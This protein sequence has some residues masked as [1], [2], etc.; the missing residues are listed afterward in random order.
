MSSTLTAL[1]LSGWNLDD[2]E[3]FAVSLPGSPL[4]DDNYFSEEKNCGHNIMQRALKAFGVVTHDGL[5]IAG[6]R[7]PTKKDYFDLFNLNID[8]FSKSDDHLALLFRTDSEKENKTPFLQGAYD[9][10]KPE[11]AFACFRQLAIDL[12]CTEPEGLELWA[13]ENHNL[14]NA[15]GAAIMVLG[16][17][18][19]TVTKD[20]ATAV[21][22]AAKSSTAATPAVAKRKGVTA[23]AAAKPAMTEAMIDQ[24]VEKGKPEMSEWVDAL[25][26]IGKDKM[27]GV[28]KK[29]GKTTVFT[30]I[31]KLTVKIATTWKAEGA[32][33]VGKNVFR[34]AAN[35]LTG[36]ILRRRTLFR[37]SEVNHDITK[38]LPPDLKRHEIFIIENEI[39]S[40]GYNSWAK[41]IVTMLVAREAEKA[42]ANRVPNDALRA[43]S[44][45]MDDKYRGQMNIIMSNVKERAGLDLSC[46]PETAMYEAMALDFNDPKYVARAPKEAHLINWDHGELDPNDVRT[47]VLLG[48]ARLSR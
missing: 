41:N 19:K 46:S 14:M 5:K 35:E 39:E 9:V 27:A 32:T 21:H 24:L 6:A 11:K 29:K 8:V 25:Q 4:T 48:V 36:T 2:D 43:S 40:A 38:H 26:D 13:S 45:M 22:A 47:V 15:Y 12:A 33:F 16:E 17:L 44:I 3:G 28:G 42:N 10:L 20:A 18:Y 23:P 31:N 1:T 37:M 7:V 34:F 30:K